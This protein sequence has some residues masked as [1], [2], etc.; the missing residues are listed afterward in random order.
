MATLIKNI[1]LIDGSGQPAI[2]ADVLIK[3]EKIAAIG[4]F[5]RYQAETIID[6]V[7]AYL[8]PG[9]ID[10]NTNSDRYLTI[11]SNPS[12]GHFLLQGITTIIGG[13]DGISLA[14][15]LYGA[16][17]LQAYW[18]NPYQI[19]IDWHT[20][21]E[22]FD[23]LR[24]RPIGVNFG[25]FVGHSTIRH[26]IIGNDFRDL[27]VKELGVLHY[28]VDEALQDGAFGVSFDLQSPIAALTPGKEIKSIL[29][30]VEKYKGLGMFKLRGGSDTA[31]SAKDVGDN[32]FPAVNEVISLSRETGVRTQISNFSPL[33]GFEVEYRQ[34]IDSIEENAAVADVYFNMHPFAQSVVPI[35]S[36]L[37]I[38][39]Q[40]GGM[41]EILKSLDTPELF[42]K[43]LTDMSAFPDEDIIIYDAPGFE[44]LV[45]KPL[46]DFGN[47]RGTSMPETMLTL[48][49]ITKLRATLL[50]NNLSLSELGKALTCDRSIVASSGASFP[51]DRKQSSRVSLF[52]TA[53]P[54]FLG[55]I[56]ANK[57]IPIE[58]AVRK[59]TSVPA[60][61]LGI[62][63]R[64]M[65]REGYFAD[66]VLFRDATIETV[67]VNGVAAVREGA[68]TDGMGGRVLK[69]TH[70]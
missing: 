9:F 50:Y 42:A 2:K 51:N 14:P 40:R 16:L 64:G 26:A 65:I 35:V 38:W 1:L 60:Q 48:M 5:P 34:A 8:A 69:H 61:R 29:E 43:I 27:T 56:N 15:L 67:F 13:Q 54:T 57:T 30:V 19:N 18:T 70:E 25:T 31:V 11:F 66:L 24:R 62:K 55:G 41:D 17:D 28:M 10:I 20:I 37:P 6:G 47:D 21:E 46:R 32:F 23:V 39:A 36:F 68:L 52:D 12:Q 44:S 22:F 7:G 49:R 53:V 63:N 33:K 4:S 3:D 45:G 58:M 59:M